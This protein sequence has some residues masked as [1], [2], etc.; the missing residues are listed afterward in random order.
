MNNLLIKQMA[1]APG[2][3][4]KGKEFKDYWEA[5]QGASYIPYN[6][7]PEEVDLDLLE[8][9]GTIDDDTV[10]EKLQGF[11]HLLILFSL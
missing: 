5:D 11:H 1:W 3:G 10:P 2:K 7:L 8:E 6:K 4:M 9:G